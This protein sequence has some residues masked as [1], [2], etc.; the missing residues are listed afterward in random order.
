MWL[1]NVPLL[2]FLHC[3][4]LEKQSWHFHFKVGSLFLGKISSFCSVLFGHPG[5]YLFIF[6]GKNC[7]AP[8][9]SVVCG[10]HYM[11]SWPFSV[12]IDKALKDTLDNIL[13]SGYFDQSQTQTHQ[14]GVC[15]EEEEEQQQQQQPAPA[16]SVECEEQPAEPGMNHGCVHMTRIMSASG[17]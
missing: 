8:N 12:F 14:N 2:I 13:L 16:E 5:I 3:S 11:H 6:A 1:H 7:G 10:I 17:D 4:H 15:E 9:S